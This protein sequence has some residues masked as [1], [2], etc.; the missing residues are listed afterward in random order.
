[1]KK[2]T[3]VLVGCDAETPMEMEVT[4]QEHQFL[5]RLEKQS[6]EVSEYQCMP[7]IRL[8]DATS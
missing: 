6:K 2:I 4:E 3:V 8:E 5:L 7:T 1:M